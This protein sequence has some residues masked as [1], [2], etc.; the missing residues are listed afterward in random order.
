M[1]GK[2]LQ[3]LQLQIKTSTLQD[4]FATIQKGDSSDLSTRM[5]SSAGSRSDTL[6]NFHLEHSDL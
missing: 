6:I 5:L 3:S 2:V 1:N 4:E